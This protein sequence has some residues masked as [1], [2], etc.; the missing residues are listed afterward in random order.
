MSLRR[1]GILL[2]KEFFRG[3]RNFIIWAIAAP[4][5][6]SLVVSLVFGTLFSEKP[7]LGIVDEGSSQL[8]AMSRELTSVDTREYG[9]VPEIKQ[10]VESGAVDM[11]IVLPE[12]FDG[13]VM[14]GEEMELTAYIWGESLAKQRTIL[15]VTIA[16]LVRELAGQ[17]APVEIESITLGD[18]VGIPW[19]DRL[20]PLIV[21]FAV[22]FGGIFL[23]AASVINEKTKKTLEALVVTPTTV[24]DVFMAKGLLGIIFSLFMGIV[25]L[26]LNRAFGAEPA[27][28]VLVLAFAAIMAVEI[29]LILGALMRDITS[30]FTVW[31]LGGILLF[32]PA[33]IYLFPQ[34]PQWIGRIFPT[35]YFIEPIVQ[36][37]QRAGGWPDIATSVF[38]LIAMDLI[39]VGVL[40]FT[41]KRTRQHIV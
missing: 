22:I 32:A 4:L 15:L 11:G 36:I 13:F 18:E 29:G 9:T 20:L 31:K 8:V 41:L 12:G 27:L 6:I 5:I 3:P 38:I 2:V 23:P 26:V 33:F 14:Q 10:A 21:L 7:K 40:I 25:I 1:V 39:L 30:L 16:N 24:G 34:I 37:S 28:L 17:E 35:Y 19:N